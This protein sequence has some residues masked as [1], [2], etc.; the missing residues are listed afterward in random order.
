MALM[1]SAILMGRQAPL[2]RVQSAESEF[3]TSKTS[4]ILLL[5]SINLGQEAEQGASELILVQEESATEAI[6]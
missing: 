3:I 1:Q 6:T 5:W 4:P 2:I